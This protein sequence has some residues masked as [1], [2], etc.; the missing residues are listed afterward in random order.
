MTRAFSLYSDLNENPTNDREVVIY[1]I[2]SINQA[3]DNILE[4]IKGERLFN[5]SGIDPEAR[6]FELGSEEEAD[7]FLNELILELTNYEPRIILDLGKTGVTPDYDNN[8]YTLSL[9]F[10]LQGVDAKQFEILRSL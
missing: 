6:L 2:A 10:G 7:S 1:D 5:D 4:L 3:V 9:V 8:R